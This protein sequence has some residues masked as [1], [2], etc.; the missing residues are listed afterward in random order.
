MQNISGKCILKLANSDLFFKSGEKMELF[1]LETKNG[2][3]TYSN[4]YT[5]DF[6]YLVSSYYGEIKTPELFKKYLHVEK[7]KSTLERENGSDEGTHQSLQDTC[8]LYIKWGEECRQ[9]HDWG[10]FCD[11][12][13]QIVTSGTKSSAQLLGETLN[14]LA[15]LKLYSN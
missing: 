13:G 7:G 14:N 8:D 5:E 2:D 6:N 15:S 3:V 12:V 11:D 4:K 1:N 9:N 10:A